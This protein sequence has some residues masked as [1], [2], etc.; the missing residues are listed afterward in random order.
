MLEN[1]IKLLDGKYY[2]K[3]ELLSKMLDDEFYYGFI[4]NGRLAAQ[5]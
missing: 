4:I 1:Q 3:T 5:V 2:D